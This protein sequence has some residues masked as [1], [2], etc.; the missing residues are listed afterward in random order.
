MHCDWRVNSYMRLV[1]DEI[2]G[3]D[4]FRNEI[5][6][7]YS[8]PGKNDKAYTRKHDSILFYVKNPLNSIF[9]IQR[10]EHKSGIHNKGA[11]LGKKSEDSADRAAE[12]E[13]QGKRL[14]DWWADV[15]TAD[16]KRDEIVGYP[17]Q[18]PEELLKRIIETWSQNMANR[19]LIGFFKLHRM[20][21]RIPNQPLRIIHLL[22]H[23]IASINASA[24]TN[25]HVLQAIA[26]INPCRAHLNADAAIN[27]IAQA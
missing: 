2:F 4:N 25:A 8:G 10:I 24:T 9:N 6:W 17:T 23:L 7:C 13:E 15:F 14:E 20:L 16:R 12:L 18:K 22:H 19:T 21:C 1:L 27:A 26:N 3:K 11:F 5:A